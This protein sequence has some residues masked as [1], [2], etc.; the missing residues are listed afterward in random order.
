MENPK[1]KTP[2][3]AKDKN[4]LLL[5]WALI[6]LVAATFVLYFF[7]AAK[8]GLSLGDSIATL[9]PLALILGF[10]VILFNKHREVMRGGPMH[11]ELSRRIMDASLGRAY[12]LSIYW[13]LALGMFSEEIGLDAAPAHAITGLIILGM[14]IL[15]GLCY[16]YTTKFDS[17]IEG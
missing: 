1:G 2:K 8:D 10:A 4:R 6:I 7:S 15:F 13:V 5:G 11:D 9:L 12:L 17:S 16:I 3:N 14:A